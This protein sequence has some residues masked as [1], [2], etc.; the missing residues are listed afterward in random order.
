VP[1]HE[2]ARAEMLIAEARQAIKEE[3]PLIAC[4]R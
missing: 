3:A 1:A 4:A 2:K